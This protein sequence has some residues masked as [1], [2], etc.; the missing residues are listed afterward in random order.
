MALP[1]L[2]LMDDEGSRTLRLTP[3]KAN[4][5]MHAVAKQGDPGSLHDFHQGCKENNGVLKI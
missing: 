3:P 4:P 2:S 1:W 5:A